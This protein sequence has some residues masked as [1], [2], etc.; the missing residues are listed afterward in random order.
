MDL[1]STSPNHCSRDQ[2]CKTSVIARAVLDAGTETFGLRCGNFAAVW[3]PC[4][5]SCMEQ[6]TGRRLSS[7]VHAGLESGPNRDVMKSHLWQR[8]L[9]AIGTWLFQ[10]LQ[11]SSILSL[12]CA[13]LLAQISWT[14]S[15]TSWCV[16]A[17][18]CSLAYPFCKDTRT[19]CRS[20]EK[21]AR[22]HGA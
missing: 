21:L 3:R 17:W 22:H 4:G 8:L 15:S 11:L 14:A 5:T 13:G 6:K 10:V 19:R 16:A 18:G 9:P 1:G 7:P 20:V 12:V 2:G